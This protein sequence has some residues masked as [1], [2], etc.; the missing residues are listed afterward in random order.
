MQTLIASGD[1]AKRKGIKLGD[2]QRRRL[3][4]KGLFPKRVQVSE[5]THAYVEQEI[6]QH[7]ERCITE[8][9]SA[10]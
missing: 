3:E 10:A 1:L 7:I 4:D 6:D 5:R 2:A 8:R 9:D